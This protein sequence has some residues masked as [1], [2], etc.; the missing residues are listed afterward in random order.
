MHDN[1]RLRLLVS[2]VLIAP[3]LRARSSPAVHVTDIDN[4]FATLHRRHPLCQCRTVSTDLKVPRPHAASTVLDDLRKLS[5]TFSKTRCGR[6]KSSTA[7]S[8][9]RRAR[10]CYVAAK[11]TVPTMF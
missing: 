7:L 11:S 2:H 6:P 3:L 5:K 8:T 9:R 10:R 4:H 1:S